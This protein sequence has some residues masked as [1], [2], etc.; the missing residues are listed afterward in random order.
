M[1]TLN[2][3]I[4]KN[5]ESIW[6]KSAILGSLWA[7][8][9]IIAGNFLHSLKIPFSGQ[10]LA[11]ASVVLLIAVFQV[12]NIKGIII[13]AGIICAV[14]KL[15]SPGMNIFGPVIAIM[16]EAA[17]IELAIL[18]FGKNLPAYLI[19]GGF[20][21]VWVLL[22]RIFNYLILYGTD[23]IILYNNIYE[24]A[25]K[26]IPF[27]SGSPVMPLVFLVVIYML[28]GSIAALIGYIVGRKAL[29]E[30]GTS[31]SLAAINTGDIIKPNV[32]FRYSKI[33]LLTVF[34]IT[35]SFLSLNYFFSI[36]VKASF[37]IA[38]CILIL[39]WYKP[40]IKKIV[41]PKFWIPVIAITLLASYFISGVKDDSWGLNSNGL[42]AG[43][44]MSL[45]AV[46][47]IFNFTAISVE[48]KKPLTD[49]ILKSGR[50]KNFS[51]ALNLAFSSV[52]VFI[53]YISQDSSFFRRPFKSLLKLISTLK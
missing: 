39:I 41:K 44:E 17:L 2:E 53:Y 12:W 37:V 18:I 23:L 43:I 42:S 33:K 13:R 8:F 52:P 34:I 29:K 47:L 49:M 30:T 24:Y 20:A 22:Q 6:I 7:S 36:Y 4:K 21:I 46:F 1:N 50:Y 51:N 11:S 3:I 25:L 31:E 16:A 9:E 32:N 48:L 45:R 10:F 38:S 28:F 19:G 5:P 40:V 35:V 26:S 14:M 15:F 27:A